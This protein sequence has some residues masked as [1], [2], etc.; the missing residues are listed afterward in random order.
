MDEPRPSWTLLVVRYGVPIGL[1]IAGLVILGI[2]RSTTGAEGW[3][4]LT[5]AAG[6]IALLNGLF[7]IG[8]RGDVERGTEATARDYLTEH[9]DWP[10]DD[11]HAE[12]RGRRW[13]LAR[14]VVTPEMEAAEA[15]GAV[16]ATEAA[17]AAAERQAAPAPERE[18]AAREAAAGDAA[19][20]GPRTESS[21]RVPGA[22]G[23]SATSK[24]GGRGD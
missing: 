15:A 14:G 11:D 17:E 10:E 4:M 18:A 5:G 2:D 24:P 9:G 12:P 13:V 7:R 3:A 21:G 22:S 23:P 6:A 1:V 16:E 19:A 8:V 20:G